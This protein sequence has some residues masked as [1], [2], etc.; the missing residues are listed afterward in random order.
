VT[1]VTHWIST[2]ERSKPQLEADNRAKA[3]GELD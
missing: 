1:G 2:G 3:S